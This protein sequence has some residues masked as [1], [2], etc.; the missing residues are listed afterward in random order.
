MPLLIDFGNAFISIL[1]NILDIEL[2]ENSDTDELENF[3]T[4]I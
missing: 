1:L 3:N 2:E 4:G